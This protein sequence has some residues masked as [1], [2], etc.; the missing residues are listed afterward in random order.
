MYISENHLVKNIFLTTSSHN[1]IDVDLY[2]AYN[3]RICHIFRAH[4]SGHV[5]IQDV[6]KNT[7]E[8]R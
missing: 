8:V 4:A 3:C 2:L 6:Y 5:Y 1:V 7:P